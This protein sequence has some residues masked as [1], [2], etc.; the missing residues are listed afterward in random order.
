MVTKLLAYYADE[1]ADYELPSDDA[2]NYNIDFGSDAKPRAGIDSVHKTI[3]VK[4][5]HHY[6][7]ELQP[8]TTDPDLSITEYPEFLEPN[9][10]ARVTLT[11]SPNELRDKPLQGGSWDFTKIVY[12]NTR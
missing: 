1:K 7:M 12:A 8:S 4:N 3:W 11:F 5:V 2:G 9:Q 10:I 6:P